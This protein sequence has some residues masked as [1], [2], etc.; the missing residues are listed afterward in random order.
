MKTIVRILRETS[1]RRDLCRRLDIS[2][3]YAANIANG[4]PVGGT[5]TLARI[6]AR[7]GLDDAEIGASVRE[8]YPREFA[9]SQADPASDAA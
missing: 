9:A 7:L 1:P 6:A 3:Q 2:V 8:M 4:K 5:E